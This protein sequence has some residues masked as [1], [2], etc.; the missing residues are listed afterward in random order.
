MV[1]TN[2]WTFVGDVGAWKG[3]HV[4]DEA[5]ME[6]NLAL[7]RVIAPQAGLTVVSGDPLFSAQAYDVK[8]VARLGFDGCTTD[9]E[10]EALLST[11]SGLHRPGTPEAFENLRDPTDGLVISGGGNLTSAW[12]NCIY[13]RLAF[14]RQASRVGAPVVF[15]GQT[16]GPDLK[17]HHRDMLAEML[18]MASWI[19]VRE[20]Q[21]FALAIELGA[22]PSKISYQ[23]DD[24]AALGLGTP[25]VALPFPATEPWIAVTVHPV[26][27]PT[28]D[29]P[30][31]DALA[32]QLHEI[33]RETGCRLVFIPHAKAAPSLG[34]PWS[35]ED[36]GNAL[37]RRLPPGMLHTLEVMRARNVA[38][39]TG[40]AA[41]VV[42]SRYHPIV[43]G[44]AAGVPCLGL[45]TDSYTL[46]KLQ[47]ALNHYGRAGDLCPI[48]EAQ[49]G[50]VARMAMRLWADKVTIQHTIAEQ[51]LAITA[52]EEVRK[53]QLRDFIAQRSPV[54]ISQPRRLAR[55]LAF[56]NRQMEQAYKEAEQQTKSIASDFEWLSASMS[57]ATRYAAS[58]ERAHEEASTYAKS[59]ESKLNMIDRQQLTD[60]DWENF[61][62][63]GFL[64]LGQVLSDSEVAGLQAHVDL[65]VRGQ[66]AHPAIQPQ[67]EGGGR[68]EA[69][70][71]L[72]N[73]PDEIA[74]APCLLQ[75]LESDELFLPLIQQPI[76]RKINAE[77]Y[78]AHASVAA[79]HAMIMNAPAG[80]GTDWGWSQG[81]GTA[82]QLDRD[83]LITVC[84]AL[85]P[86]TQAAGCMEV[87]IGSHKMGLINVAGNTLSEEDARIRCLPEKMTSLEVPAGHAVLLHNWLIR[88]PGLNSSSVARR[89]FSVC[90]LDARTRSI[91]TGSHFPLVFGGAVADAEPYVLKLQQECAVQIKNLHQAEQSTLALLQRNDELS[92]SIE[93]ALKY[94]HVLEADLAGKRQKELDLDDLREENLRLRASVAQMHTEVVSLSKTV[95][96]LTGPEA[97]EWEHVQLELQRLQTSV[98]AAHAAHAAHQV[99]LHELEQLRAHAAGLQHRL[100][101]TY[102]SRSWRITRPVRAVS[103]LLRR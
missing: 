2:N 76:F 25:A 100:E 53:L 56:A 29:D 82:R 38:R 5:M 102:A 40:Q 57:E 75:G 30:L 21:S 62:R 20:E 61:R 31:L 65:L 52:D 27:D 10:R 19:G 99:A 35:D 51:A 86:A 33:A 67:P 101:A 16:L 49:N 45:W 94:T 74:H 17:P 58:L 48:H 46:V 81:G 32:D 18:G 90:Y 23:L 91:E 66:A 78:G 93:S 88:R 12:P 73:A 98:A 68:Y 59:L 39:L 34:A 8:A 54:E 64:H 24:A 13:E 92:K 9:D 4:G 60:A 1:M 11:L 71:E 36:V 83:P 87:V 42:S 6:A 84:V 44:L 89:A 50:R 28:G 22:P 55:A 37:A 95:A 15:L 80:C 103:T 97:L 47:G 69:L 72:E 77:I 26:V 3:Y 41:L 7:F 14:C 70:T 43:F 85:D 79:S 63:D 96:T